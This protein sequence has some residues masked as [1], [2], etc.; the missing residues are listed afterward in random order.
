MVFMS[1]APRYNPNF[2]GHEQVEHL[3]LQGMSQHKFPHAFL[4]QGP[5]GVGKATFAFRLARYLLSQGKGPFREVPSLAIDPTTAL[6][7]RIA[8]GSHGDLCTLTRRPLKDGA[9]EKFITVDEVRRAI[10]FSRK[11]PAECGWRV[12]IIDSADDLNKNAANAL[13]KLLEEPLPHSAILLTASMPGRLPVTIRSRCQVLNF[14]VLSQEAVAAV[15]ASQ[16]LPPPSPTL[17]ALGQGC[18]G[19]MMALEEAQGEEVYGNLL[20]LL[21]LAFQGQ[22]M[23]A[24]MGFQRLFDQKPEAVHLM[25][26][27]LSGFIEKVILF[28]TEPG[29]RAFSAP[30]AAALVHTKS[31]ELAHWVQVW[32]RIQS[33]QRQAQIFNLDWRQTLEGIVH[34]IEA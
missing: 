8:A 14:G 5:Q 26:G 3:V 32:Q 27:F 18:P 34:L 19:K 16:Q 11:T 9:L 25:L 7:K 15:Y 33:F 1:L 20:K 10:S 13:L 12:V 24:L 17:R 2:F 31:R 28:L 4:L 21:T 30:E 6:F 29:Q 23:R 22:G